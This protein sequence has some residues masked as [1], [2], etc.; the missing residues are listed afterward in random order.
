M[1]TYSL[2]GAVQSGN[3]SQVVSLLD[4]IKANA[5]HSKEKTYLVAK[6][7]NQGLVESNITA[8]HVACKMYSLSFG[9]TKASLNLMIEALLQAG[10]DPYAL[11]F[12]TKSR[13]QED[14][15][16]PLMCCNYDIP[17]SL[18]AFLDI[19]NKPDKDQSL[20]IPFGWASNGLS[21]EGFGELSMMLGHMQNKARKRASTKAIRQVA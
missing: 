2:I 15:I 8:I 19:R 1:N 4:T 16:T 14:G 6:E 10:A 9:Q 18:Q 20:G 21:M 7:V 5:S 17:Q 13:Y 12:M 11:A 3:L